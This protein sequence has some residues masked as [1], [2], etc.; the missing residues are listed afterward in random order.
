MTIFQPRDTAKAQALRNAAT[1]A[2]RK[3][4]EYLSRS[5][6]GGFKFSRQIPIAPFVA[7]FV[8]RTHKLIIELDGESHDFSVEADARRTSFLESK[9][10][11]VL[12]FTNADVFERAEGVVSMI[13]SALLES[14]TPSPSRKREGG[15]EA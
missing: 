11:R 3:L 13:L 2:E 14:P 8:C 12:S 10:Y 9:G 6:V 5:Q 15:Q 4:W 1:P 7:D